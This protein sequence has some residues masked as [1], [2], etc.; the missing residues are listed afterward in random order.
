MINASVLFLWSLLG[1]QEPTPLDLATL[2]KSGDLKIAEIA[3]GKATL[4]GDQWGFLSTPGDYDNVEIE[5]SVTLQ[6][7]AKQFGYFGQHWS[8]WPDLRYPDQGFEAA[9]LF[10]SDKDSGYRVQF[11]HSLQQ[12][13]LVKYRN[14]GYLRSVPCTLK[15]KEPH[16]IGVTVQGQ[17]IA[18]RVDGQEKILYRDD[19]RPLEKGRLGIGASSGAKVAFE[20]VTL[21][22]LPIV[23]G[24]PKAGHQPN[25]SV[26]KWIGGKPWV[27]DGDEPILM[28]VTAEQPYINSVKLR[29]GFKPLLSWNSFW[30]TSN[31]GAFPEGKVK[32]SAEATL[33]G[34]GQTLTATWGAD[35]LNGRFVQRMKMQVG[36]DGVRSTYTYDVDSELEVLPG[37]PFHFRYGYDFEH[38]T[39]LDPFSWQYVIMRRE[40]GR[41][42]H[43]PVYPV[44]PGGTD[45]LEQSGGAKVWYG[46]HTETML[47]APAVEYN[48]PDAGRRKMNTAVCAAFYDTGVGLAAETAPAGTK[49]RVK[50]RYTGWPAEEAEKLWRASTICETPMLDPEH[51]YIFADEWPK[52]TFSKFVPMSETWIYGRRPFM[53]GHNQR[54][55][56]ALEKNAGVG[57]GFAMKLGPGAFGASDLPIPAPLPEGNY[58]VTSWCKVVNAH[59]PG[60]RIEVAAKDKN[61]KV[62]R[63]E[64]HFVGNGSFDWK[65]IGFVSAVPGGA[66][67]LSVGFGNGGTGD[68]YFTEVE[69]KKRE[70]DAPPLPAANAA[71]PQIDPSP[72]GALF[73]YRMLEQKGRFSYD[74]ARGPI[75]TLELA[76]VDWTVDEGRAALKFAEPAPGRRD[77]TRMGAIERNYLRTIQ[78]S[79]TPMAIAGFHGGGFDLQAFTLSTWIKP[80]ATMGQGERGQSAGDIVGL[81][82]RRFILRLQSHQAPYPLQAALNVNDRFQSVATVPADRWSHVAMTA[83]PTPAKKW[84]VRIYLNGKKVAEGVTEKMDASGQTAPSLIFGSELFYLHDSWYRGLIGRTMLLDRALGE[85][86]IAELAQ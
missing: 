69:F 4:G 77:V 40:G 67:A 74:Y 86:Q 62:L 71:P 72:A 24:G 49:V 68:V 57:S 85:A 3:G 21:K 79:G 7:P 65:K 39:P 12:V 53:S 59:G 56:Y 32:I 10:R 20:K 9:L 16:R 70:G 54:P 76:N 41:I 43:R 64:T 51:H 60:G 29:P 44:D 19:L 55:T 25:F 35:S 15:L 8:V 52:L 81:G 45:D 37:D 28:L 66:A 36:W 2:E 13:A 61:G 5:A 11:S 50:Y 33:T 17:R 75:G 22:A 31:Q 26:R 38:H 73:D 27:F 83:E 78:W 48:L 80:A 6:E 14:G 30:D 58:A 63:Q 23:G 84:R 47:V 1:A 18:V 46:R 82:A 34:G 42:N